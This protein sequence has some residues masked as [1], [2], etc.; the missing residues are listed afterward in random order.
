LRRALPSDVSDEQKQR[1]K[2]DYWAA[3]KLRPTHNAPQ[4]KWGQL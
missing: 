1:L 3:E 4:E 2:N